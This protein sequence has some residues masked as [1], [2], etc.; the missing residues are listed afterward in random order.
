MNQFLTSNSMKKIIVLS[1]MP[2][3]MKHFG[4][5]IWLQFLDIYGGNQFSFINENVLKIISKYTNVKYLK[6]SEEP[7]FY[8]AQVR[9]YESHLNQIGDKNYG[10]IHSHPII[11]LLSSKLIWTKRF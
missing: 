4:K 11:S 1:Q 3:L 9:F 2:E 8:E 5:K 7:L 6:I 10:I